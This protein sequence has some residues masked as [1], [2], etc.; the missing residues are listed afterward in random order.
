MPQVLQADFSTFLLG[1]NRSCVR[2]LNVAFVTPRASM[3][4]GR[5]D[6]HRFREL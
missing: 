2:P 1:F 3:L 4:F 5:L 6:P